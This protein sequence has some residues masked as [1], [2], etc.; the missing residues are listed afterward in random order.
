[1]TWMTLNGRNVTLAEI[2]KIS[3][4]HSKNFN[5]DRSILLAVK[6]RPMILVARN[7]RY[8]RGCAWG[9]HQGGGVTYNKCKRLAY[10][11][12]GIA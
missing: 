7:T 9:F 2:N 8:I 4:A 11:Q 12:R 6:C 3:G 5:E 1:M 10:V